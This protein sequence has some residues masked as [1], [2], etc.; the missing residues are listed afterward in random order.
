VID[1]CARL[2]A[3]KKA[4]PATELIDANAR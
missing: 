3:I 2:G 4:F 1:T